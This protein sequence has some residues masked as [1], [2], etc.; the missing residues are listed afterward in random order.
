VRVLFGIMDG[1]DDALMEIIWS[2]NIE[3]KEFYSSS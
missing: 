2:E 1:R 3:I